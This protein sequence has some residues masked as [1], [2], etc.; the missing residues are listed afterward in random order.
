MAVGILTPVEGTNPTLWMDRLG[1]IYEDAEG[2]IPAGSQDQ[3]PFSGELPDVTPGVWRTPS[4]V[5]MDRDAIADMSQTFR[6]FQSTDPF[7]QTMGATGRGMALRLEPELQA[8][9]MLGGM[10]PGFAEGMGTQ[11]GTLGPAGSYREFIER[12]PARWNQSQW[13]S[14]LNALRNSKVLPTALDPNLWNNMSTDEKRNQVTAHVKELENNTNMANAWSTLSDMD[15]ATITSFTEGLLGISTLPPR[16][17]ETYKWSLRRELDRLE[18]EIPDLTTNP[19]SLITY[20]SLSGFNLRGLGIPPGQQKFSSTPLVT[21]SYKEEPAPTPKEIAAANLTIGGAKGEGEGDGAPPEIKENDPKTPAGKQA[22]TTFNQN[23]KSGAA[24]IPVNIPDLDDPDYTPWKQ[25][26][27]MT[28]EGEPIYPGAFSDL[29]KVVRG[30]ETTYPA[31]Y[32]AARVSEPAGRV[33][34][35]FEGVT[36]FDPLTPEEAAVPSASGVFGTDQNQVRRKYDP[37]FPTEPTGGPMGGPGAAGLTETEF[38]GDPT[39]LQPGGYPRTGYDPSES[40]LTGVMGDPT[41]LTPY[42]STGYDPTASPLT[43][44]QQGPFT[45]FVEGP[46]YGEAP[47]GDVMGIEGAWMHTPISQTYPTQEVNIPTTPESGTFGFR[48]FGEAPAEAGAIESY[49]R[50]IRSRYPDVAAP[51]SPFDWLPNIS[52]YHMYDEGTWSGRKEMPQPGGVWLDAS[53]NIRPEY[54]APMTHAEGP[55]GQW[56][57]YQPRIQYDDGTYGGRLAPIRI[58]A[59]DYWFHANPGNR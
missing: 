7:F 10:T 3:L 15:F 28:A 17:Y 13:I 43:N 2:T 21:G 41:L 32:D 24:H 54:D 48:G 18:R 52:P 37:G 58:P 19:A 46:T 38:M 44:V 14:G 8:R 35:D 47:V 9:Y 50:G 56:E 26:E 25:A 59:S 42:T 53:G 33:I 57:W 51:P 36:P 30:K 40:P 20:L 11:Q 5:E 34:T 27:L 16:M 1:D 31:G 55:A 49:P 22:G 4:E 12:R 6:R 45:E 39:L 23:V 29:T